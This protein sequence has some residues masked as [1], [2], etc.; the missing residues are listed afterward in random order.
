M[1]LPPDVAAAVPSPAEAGS[2]PGEAGL[3]GLLLLLEAPVLI[4]TDTS[5]RPPS[6]DPDRPGG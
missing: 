6:R 1:D 5:A 2:L 4:R 3:D